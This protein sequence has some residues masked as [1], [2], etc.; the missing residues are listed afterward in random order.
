MIKHSR[1]TFKLSFVY[2]TTLFTESTK[3]SIT[4]VKHFRKK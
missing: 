4:R 1:E 3:V 2:T